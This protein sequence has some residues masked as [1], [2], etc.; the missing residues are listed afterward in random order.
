[1]GW[2]GRSPL[3]PSPT[4]CVGR[5]ARRPGPSVR[6]PVRPSVPSFPAQPAPAPAFVPHMSKGEGVCVCV[7]LRSPAPP[8]GPLA[9]PSG[10]HAILV[11][12]SSAPQTSSFTGPVQKGGEGGGVS[13]VPSGLIDWSHPHSPRPRTFLIRRTLDPTVRILPVACP[14]PSTPRAAADLG[15]EDFGF[16]HV[17]EGFSN[18]AIYGVLGPRVLKAIFD[19]YNCCV[20]AY[21]QTGARACVFPLDSHPLPSE[22]RA[23]PLLTA[24]PGGRREDPPDPPSCSTVAVG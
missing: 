10:G 14:P 2:V 24:H 13:R 3:S 17:F 18:E 5:D 16:D 7:R 8:G 6:P 15:E 20:F 11:N 1:L 19:G 9:V 4:K 21:G 22:P 12:D 23:T